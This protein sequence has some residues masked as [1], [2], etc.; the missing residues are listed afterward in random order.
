M[1]VG[2]WVP[3]TTEQLETRVRAGD[4]SE[5]AGFEAKRELGTAFKIARAVAGMAAG[6]G[7]IVYGLDEDDHGQP[8]V[9]APLRLDGAAER[10]DNIVRD[11]IRE[12]PVVVTK[13]LRLPDD[14]SRGYLVVAVPASPRAPHMV[15]LNSDNRFYG[16]SATATRPLEEYEIALFYERRARQA[17]DRNSLLDDVVAWHQPEP[18]S[19]HAEMHAFV[20]PVRLDEDLWALAST[21]LES[22]AALAN[23]LSEAARDS[24]LSLDSYSPDLKQTP[25]ETFG[26]AAYRW[27]A[28]G[29]AERYARQGQLDETH[30]S[31]LCEVNESG[32]GR[33]FFN[34]VGERF[35]PGNRMPAQE[36]LYLWPDLAL[37]TLTSFVVMVGELYRRARYY[38]TVDLGIQLRGL[39]GGVFETERTLRTRPYES[40]AERQHGRRPAVDLIDRPATVAFD[41]LR[42]FLERLYGEGYTLPLRPGRC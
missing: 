24:P 17:V 16:R 32:E 15:T 6:G 31:L 29:T 3:E 36:G 41:L 25:W 38:G 21:E 40:D 10:V 23:A 2:M 35:T 20:R 34:R 14:P 33:L 27:I 5:H 18:N 26:G 22:R 13:P 28:R 12:A 19:L 42:G 9:L 39:G 4:V 37:G 8:T 7:V 1:M 11:G 30:V